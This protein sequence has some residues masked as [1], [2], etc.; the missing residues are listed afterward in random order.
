MKN[1]YKVKKLILAGALLSA[2]LMEGFEA[3]QLSTK[4]TTSLAANLD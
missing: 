2:S 1:K 4:A 3:M